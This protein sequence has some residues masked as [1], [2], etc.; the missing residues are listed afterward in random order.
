[1]KKYDLATKTFKSFVDDE[2]TKRKEIRDKLIAKKISYV[3]NINGIFIQDKDEEKIF[4]IE[5][6]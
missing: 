6:N 1:M 3:E 4:N 5:M 2:E